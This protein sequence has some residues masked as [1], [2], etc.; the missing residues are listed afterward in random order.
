V[1]K[2]GGREAY[3]SPDG[4]HVYYAKEN[5]PGM[6]RVP[7][8]GGEEL[9]ILDQVRQGSWAV[10]ERGIYFVNPDERPF[11]SIEFYDF[12]TERT[13]RIATIEKELFWSGPNLASTADG[14]WILYVHTDQTESDIM[15]IEN[16]S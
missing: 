13:T 8:E 7:A 2:G 10:W 1:T 3:E 16:F 4:R 6:W 15:L 9:K 12:A 5:V 14:R 11:P